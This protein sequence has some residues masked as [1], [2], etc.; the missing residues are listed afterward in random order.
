MN[1][2]FNYIKNNILF[3][4]HILELR[5]GEP[6]GTLHSRCKGHDMA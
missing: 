6:H 2:I 4:L 5:T 1:L 3:K